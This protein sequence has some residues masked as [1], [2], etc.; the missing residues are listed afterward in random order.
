MKF[1]FIIQEYIKMLSRNTAMLEYNI[2]VNKLF[3]VCISSVGKLISPTGITA[4]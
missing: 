1:S 3:I 2:S 4:H